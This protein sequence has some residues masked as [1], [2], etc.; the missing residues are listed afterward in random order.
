L[1]ILVSVTI[2]INGFGRIGQ[3]LMRIVSAAP[4]SDIIVGAINDI[5]TID[6][7]AG[8]LRRDS[9]RGNFPGTISHTCD[10]LFVNGHAI[11]VF[12]TADPTQIPWA[13]TGSEVVIDATGRFRDGDSAR[14]HITHGGARKVIISASAEKPDA[15]LVYGVNHH[16]YDPARHHVISPASCGV[17][18]LSMMAKVLLDEFGLHGVHTSVILGIQAWGKVSDTLV[19]ASRDDPRLGR[20]VNDNIIPHDYVAGDLV[21]TVLPGLGEILSSYYCVPTPIGSMAE[22]TGR[23]AR[24]LTVDAVNRA[25]AAAAD[26]PLRGMLHYDPDPTVSSDVRGDPASCLFDPSGSRTTADGGV[27]VRGWFDNEWGFSHRLL[28]LVRLL[29]LSTVGQRGSRSDES[30]APAGDVLGRWPVALGRSLV[31]DPGEVAD[32]A[33]Y[34]GSPVSSLRIVPRRGAA[35]PP[36]PVRAHA[37]RQ[38]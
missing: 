35:C 30:C 28:D 38:S 10:K 9:V 3:T 18:A 29:G 7:L 1:E 26:G 16:D 21:R 32:E 6:R 31:P 37:R 33:P 22:V 4:D 23:A 36:R 19:G 5:A 34:G 15:V 13:Q 17:N 20:S 25:M 14:G 8:G 11:P 27:R 24:P 12:N 2:G